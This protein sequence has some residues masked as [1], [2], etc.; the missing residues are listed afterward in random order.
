MKKKKHIYMNTDDMECQYILL[1]GHVERLRKGDRIYL[2]G[3]RVGVMGIER[4]AAEILVHVEDGLVKYRYPKDTVVF[5]RP[6]FYSSSYTS[7]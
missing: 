5:D 1:R 2:G 3:R 6:I 7:H 4:L